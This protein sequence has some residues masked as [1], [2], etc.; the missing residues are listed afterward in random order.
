VDPQALPNKP[1]ATFRWGFFFMRFGR[2]CGI[3]AR[4]QRCERKAISGQPLV[5]NELVCFWESSFAKRGVIL[6]WQ[7]ASA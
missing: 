4:D 3:R 7:P 5:R 1:G 6:V 2:L